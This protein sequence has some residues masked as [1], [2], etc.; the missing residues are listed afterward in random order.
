M[1][2]NGPQKVPKSRAKSWQNPPNRAKSWQ[3]GG[4]KWQKNGVFEV[5]I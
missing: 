5:G 2:K 1:I 3:N 4:K